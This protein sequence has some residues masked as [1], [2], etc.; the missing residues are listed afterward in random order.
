MA[1][2]GLMGT[3]R[4]LWVFAALLATT[5]VTAYAVGLF[6][7]L[8]WE[9]DEVCGHQF[10]YDGAPL[11]EMRTSLL[12]LTNTCVFEDGATY[13]DIPVWVN[14]VFFASLVAAAACA[15]RAAWFGRTPR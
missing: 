3:R 8:L 9:T 15:A 1:T 4:T 6:V 11:R 7:W 2:L 10:A 14:P 13:S 12:P 5:A